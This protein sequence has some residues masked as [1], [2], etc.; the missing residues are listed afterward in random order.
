MAGVY[1]DQ[2]AFFAEQFRMY[3]YFT[4]PPKP[5]AGYNKRQPLGK[6]KGVFQYMKKGELV[7]EPDET[8]ADTNVPSLWTRKKLQVGSYFIQ[9]DDE[10]YRIVNPSDWSFEG[11]FNVYVLESFVGDSDVQKPD[12]EVD[13]GTYL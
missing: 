7:R 9:K 12:T 2:L 1:G 5:V 4:M 8:L 13:L 6:V 10:L 3:D 11:G